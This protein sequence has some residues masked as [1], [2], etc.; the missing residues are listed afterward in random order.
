MG[1]GRRL[2]TLLA[3]P[4][5]VVVWT[6]A[7]P[8]LIGLLQGVSP[9]ELMGPLTTVCTLLCLFTLASSVSFAL[10]SLYFSR[11]VEWLLASPLGS[12]VFLAHRLVSQLALGITVGGVLGGP[13]A[14]AAAL[15][16]HSPLILP[17]VAV[18]LPALLVV[19]MALALLLVVAAVRL[20]PARRVRDAAA[21]L[22]ALIGFGV[23]AA[24]LSAAFGGAPRAALPLA[25]FRHGFASPPW[26]P[27]TWAARSLQAA[28]AGH[29]P[30]ALGLSL[31][32]GGLALA[33][34]AGSI[35]VAAPALREGWFRS[36]HAS[37]RAR[38]R[39][40]PRPLP[41]LLAVLLK[42]WRI[43]RRDPGQ[44]IQLLL[45]LG[46]F[47]VYLLSPRGGEGIFRDFPAWYGPLTTSG[48]AALFAASGVGLRAVGS[49]GGRLWCLRSSP[50]G[51]GVLLIS[52]AALPAV[53]SVG[54]SLALLL[55]TEVRQGLGLWAILVSSCLLTLMVLGLVGLAVGMGAA[56]PR[57]GWTDPRRAV[58]VWLAITFMLAGSAYIA[59]CVV[60]F[61]LPL[62][63]TALPVWV[64][65]LLSLSV[66]AACAGL[67]ALV[68]LRTGSSRLGRLDL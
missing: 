17:V 33:V 63:L 22:V 3:P 24:D 37:S 27:T 48:F 5:A 16:Y 67:T 61:T 29:P 53:I 2:A 40:L 65:W 46:L 21:A 68:S 36:Q 14:V 6:A 20:A 66:C 62:L 23:A 8:E 26:L 55:A 30:E 9:G 41:P 28:A 44:L 35:A 38:R 32:L 11:D 45:P 34:V 52:K 25:A 15:R 39:H 49:E 12:G 51:P 64:G 10:A 19:P 7:V 42:D 4:V 50:L 59:L 13:V 56:W 1:A 31:A 58:G 57:L 43:L 47:A 54:A 60:L 18:D